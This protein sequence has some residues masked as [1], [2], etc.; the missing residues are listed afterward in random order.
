MVCPSALQY[1]R[2]RTLRSASFTSVVF[3]GVCIVVAIVL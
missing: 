3:T 2:P 1:T